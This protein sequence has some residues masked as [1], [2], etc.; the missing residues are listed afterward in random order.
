[1]EESV[2]QSNYEECPVCLEKTL[3]NYA[4]N[5]KHHCCVSCCSIGNLSICPQ[6]R[7][8]RRW[9]EMSLIEKY[10]NRKHPEFAGWVN[11]NPQE[12]L[13]AEIECNEALINSHRRYLIEETENDKSAILLRQ[14]QE[15][16]VRFLTVKVMTRNN[17]IQLHIRQAGGYYSIEVDF[18]VKGYTSY[19]RSIRPSIIDIPMDVNTSRLY[20]TLIYTNR[21]EITWYYKHLCVKT[22]DDGTIELYLRKPTFFTYM[23]YL[24]STLTK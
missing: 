2:N 18:D 20:Y 12:F 10:D 24:Y 11:N 8:A 3:I 6:C 5:C 9:S 15:S 4:F 17:H 7:N 14:R 23:E 19:H 1:M 16:E 21:P 22:H 13:R